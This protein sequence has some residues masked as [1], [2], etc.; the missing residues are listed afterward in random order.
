LLLDRMKTDSYGF[1]NDISRDAAKVMN[2]KG[3]AAFE[4]AAKSR[5]DQQG[6]TEQKYNPWGEVLRDIYLQRNDVSAYIALCERT[7]FSAEACLAL[8]QVIDKKRKPTEALAWVER[9]LALEKKPAGWSASGYQLR[10][11]R[12][13]LFCKLGRGNEA[14]KDAWREF[15][16]EP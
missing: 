5:F 9:S 7:E 4:R 11:M 3:L 13:E 15:Q 16:E 1:L 6:K 2:R 10:K 12:R 8:A 14:L